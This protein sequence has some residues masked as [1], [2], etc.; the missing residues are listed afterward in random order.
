MLQDENKAPEQPVACRVGCGACCIMPSI[1][2]PIPGMQ[3]GKPAGVRCIQLT[4]DNHCRLFGKSERPTV[5]QSLRPSVEMCGQS[6]EEAMAFLIKLERL[7][8]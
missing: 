1:S 3:Q 4:P 5:C 8:T 6:S 2:S 7:T